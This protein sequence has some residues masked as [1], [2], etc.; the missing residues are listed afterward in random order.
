MRLRHVVALWAVLCAQA[1]AGPIPAPGVSPNSQGRVSL[2]N[3]QPAAGYIEVT[4]R[5][6]AMGSNSVSGGVNTN[7]RGL[8]YVSNAATDL[9]GLQAG[10][11]NFQLNQGGKITNGGCSISVTAGVEYP[12]GTAAGSMTFGGSITG[13]IAPG[14]VLYTDPFPIYVPAGQVAHVRYWMQVPGGCAFPRGWIPV[15]A[16]PYVERSEEGGTTASPLSDNTVTISGTGANSYAGTNGAAWGPFS[17]RGLP[18]TP[19]PSGALIG[20]SLIW[21]QGDD[22]TGLAIAPTGDGIG[23]YGPIQRGLWAANIGMIK[24]AKSGLFARDLTAQSFNW[25]YGLQGATTCIVYLG[26]NDITNNLTLA[27][28][29]S[30]VQEVWNSCAAQGKHVVAVTIPPRTATSLGL[31][32][33]PTIAASGSGYSPSSTFNITLSGGT[34]DA[35]LGTPGT[36]AVVSV[37]TNASGVPVSVNSVV[38][39]GYYTTQP[40]SPAAT[41]ATGGGSGLTL[42]LPSFAGWLDSASQNPAGNTP[43]NAGQYGGPTSGRGQFNAWIRSKPSPV[44][45]VIDLGAAVED[46]SNTG[47]WTAKGTNDGTHNNQVSIPMGQAMV[48]V[49]VAAGAIK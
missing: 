8:A 4:N 47:R 26:T 25:K 36:A 33:V 40:S 1:L 15:F 14:G 42:T 9:A 5:P 18:V 48:A 30:A 24:L 21:G 17:I 12:V 7:T 3:Q 38:S 49:A 46:G 16:V 41:T 2:I 23:D 27:A 43:A 35:T 37:T 20:D 22:P 6:I 39:I 28:T 10:F 34:P 45:Y 32:S 31:P 44:E 29:Q 13:S 11:S 19:R